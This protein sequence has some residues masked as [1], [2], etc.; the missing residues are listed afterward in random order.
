DILAQLESIEIPQVCANCQKFSVANVKETGCLLMEDGFVDEKL[1]E[2]R[3]CTFETTVE[4]ARDSFFYVCARFCCACVK[5]SRI[6]RSNIQPSDT[7]L[8]VK[9]VHVFVVHVLAGLPAS[10]FGAFRVVPLPLACNGRVFLSC[11]AWEKGLLIFASAVFWF[12][13]IYVV[14]IL[15]ICLCDRRDERKR[16]VKI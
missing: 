5:I 13:R 11:N 12:W 9:G 7:G 16:V 4:C 14:H 1:E 10:F 2:L 3:A 6:H 15:Y 8:S